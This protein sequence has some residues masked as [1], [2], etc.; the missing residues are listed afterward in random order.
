MNRKNSKNTK[1]NK[2][3]L[4]RESIR[5]LTSSELSGAAGGRDEYDTNICKN[6]QGTECL[7]WTGNAWTALCNGN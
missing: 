3:S 6:T 2:L 5:A 4:R 7:V 1:R